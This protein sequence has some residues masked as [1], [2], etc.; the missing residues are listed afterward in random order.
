[1]FLPGESQGRGSLVSCHL[2]MGSHRVRHDWSDLAAADQFTWTTEVKPIDVENTG[3]LQKELNIYPTKHTEQEMSELLSEEGRM[4]FL[5][6]RV[7]R[8]LDSEISR[9]LV[10]SLWE[11]ELTFNKWRQH[12]QSW[13]WT[14]G[15]VLP[16]LIQLIASCLRHE[17]DGRT[18]LPLSRHD[19]CKCQWIYL[20]SFKLKFSRCIFQPSY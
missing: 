13:A 3:L 10:C 20:K 7:S 12:Q 18:R 4:S 16:P 17:W 8:D 5:W 15:L 2:S 9:P 6:Y 11:I 19:S 14:Q 1:M